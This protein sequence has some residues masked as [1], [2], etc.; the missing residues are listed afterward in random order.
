MLDNRNYSEILRADLTRKKS[1]TKWELRKKDVELVFPGGTRK[2]TILE[3]MNELNNRFRKV[4]YW[5][6]IHYGGVEEY[7]PFTNGT[8]VS[9]KYRVTF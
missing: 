6:V 9:W 8:E 7:R 3:I 5:A 4:E 2:N 1:E